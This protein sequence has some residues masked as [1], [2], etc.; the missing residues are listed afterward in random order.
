MPYRL[1]KIDPLDLNSRKA[2]G[3]KLPFESPSVF[4]PTYQTLEAYKSN[5]L[6]YLSTAKGDRYF[7]PLFGNSLLREL[8]ETYTDTKRVAIEKQLR[9]ELMHYFPKLNIDKLE[10]SEIDEAG[11][12]SLH[13]EFSVKNSDLKDELTVNFA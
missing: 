8:F 2:V 9:I 1:Y 13:I 4:T 12:C 11:A 10:L 7:N 6:N 3:L 5:L